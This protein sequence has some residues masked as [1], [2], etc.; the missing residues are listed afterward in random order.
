MTLLA[1]LHYLADRFAQ[2]RIDYLIRTRNERILY[3]FRLAD[4]RLHA[5]QKHELAAKLEA[6][7][8][9]GQRAA[10]QADRQM[11]ITRVKR[12]LGLEVE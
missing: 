1:N 10:A 9:S 7:I 8:A 6:S 2:A 12:D 3:Q 11:A 4:E 5:R